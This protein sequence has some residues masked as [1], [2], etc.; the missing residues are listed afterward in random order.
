M[1]VLFRGRWLSNKW[2]EILF[3]LLWTMDCSR[4]MRISVTWTS[5]R[6][7]IITIINCPVV[8]GEPTNF[9][10]CLLRSSYRWKARG[11]QIINVI[12]GMSSIKI[13]N[14][15][16]CPNF[17]NLRILPFCICHQPKIPNY[18]QLFCPLPLL[19]FLFLHFFP[20]SCNLQG[21]LMWVFTGEGGCQNGFVLHRGF[22]P[23]WVHQICGLL[24][25]FT[26]QRLEKMDSIGGE[27]SS[28]K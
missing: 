14:Y 21:H 11:I 27:G 24:E 26:F 5:W 17:W 2:F 18:P 9:N 3:L 25:I 23:K 8:I 16:F 19:D 28:N 20:L 22:L 7:N 15:Y 13:P 1:R 10:F 6:D 4:Q 12:G